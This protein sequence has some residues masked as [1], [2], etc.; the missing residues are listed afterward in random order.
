[1]SDESW[2]PSTSPGMLRLRARLKGRV[3][4]FFR[5]RHVLEVD[6]PI[7]SEAAPTDPHIHSLSTRLSGAVGRRF[8]QTSPE[9]PMKR[10]LAAGVGDC[11]QLARVFRDGERGSLHAPEFDLLEWYRT[12]FD[13]HRLMDEVEALLRF[14]A[15]DQC[16]VAR[17]ERVSYRAAFLRHADL[18]PLEA[19]A[20]DLAA[21]ARRHGLGDV[22]G[23]TTDDRDGWLDVL[24]TG[25]VLPALPAE[26]PVFIHAWP[27]S[28]AA[29]ARLEPKDPRVARRFELYWRGIELA[30]GFHE[31][32]DADEQRRRFDADLARRRSAGLDEPPV[33]ER[34]LAALAD[35]LPECAGVALGF[36]RLCLCIAGLD[37]LDDVLAFPPERA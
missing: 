27:A 5:R 17:A 35:G 22:P 12:G 13:H 37:D 11:W 29:L 10:L 15:A 26:Q 9:F 25:R 6:T 20:D 31:L 3:R 28:Q 24:L 8:L 36:D 30:N 33:D 14:A 16:R 18:D 4:A 19:D 7:L 34:L 32:A 23:L 1:V 2:R 21:C